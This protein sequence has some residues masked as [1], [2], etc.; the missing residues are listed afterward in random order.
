ME[1]SNRPKN[2]RKATRPLSYLWDITSVPLRV[3]GLASLSQNLIRWNAV[4]LDLIVAYRRVVHPLFWLLFYWTPWVMPTWAIDYVFF[5]FLVTTS[6][7]YAVRATEARDRQEIRDAE[8]RAEVITVSCVLAEPTK[9]TV[10][11]KLRRICCGILELLVV[12]LVK[13]VLWPLRLFLCIAFPSLLIAI[14]DHLSKERWLR[15]VMTVEEKAKEIRSAALQWIGVVLF[16]FVLLLAFS[17]VLLGSNLTKKPPAKFLVTPPIC[18][19][20]RM[21]LKPD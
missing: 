20:E 12:G 7:R 14:K 15:G 10:S 18:R 5:G 16:G 13:L 19:H 3:I 6:L 2:R 11:Q 1:R 9:E 21:K 4:V 17:R 8:K